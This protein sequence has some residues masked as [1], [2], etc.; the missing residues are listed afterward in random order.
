M[1]PEDRLR[2]M[3]SA[4]RDDSPATEREWNGFVRKARRRLYIRRAGAAVAA[5]SSVRVPSTRVSGSGAATGFFRRRGP[6]GR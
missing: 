3:T 5:M 1:N 4:A 6:A 2:Q